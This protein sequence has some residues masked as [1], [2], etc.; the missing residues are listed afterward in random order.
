[1][2][3]TTPD[4]MKQVQYDKYLSIPVDSDDL[5]LYHQSISSHSAEYAP[6]HSQIF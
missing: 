5:V 1:M 6:V 3:W 4:V 2:Y